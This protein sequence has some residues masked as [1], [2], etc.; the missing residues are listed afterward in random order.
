[1]QLQ[2]YMYMYIGIYFSAPWF[3]YI[4]FYVFVYL[5]IAKD[6]YTLEKYMYTSCVVEYCIGGFLGAPQFFTVN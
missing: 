5:C 4:L 2:Y 1:M 3:K 6:L